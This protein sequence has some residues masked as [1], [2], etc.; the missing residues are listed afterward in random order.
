MIMLKDV[1]SILVHRYI[2]VY[3]NEGSTIVAEDA[4]LNLSQGTL[5]ILAA[6]LTKYPVR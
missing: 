1:S 2:T 4:V 5:R 6:L 3:K